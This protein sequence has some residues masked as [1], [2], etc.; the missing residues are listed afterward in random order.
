MIIEPNPFHGEVVLGVIHYFN[1]LGYRI[2]LC[3]RKELMGEKL[4]SDLFFD[5]EIFVFD[6]KNEREIFDCVD[7][8]EYDFAFFTSLEYQNTNRVLVDFISYNKLK[9][10]TKY[11]ILGIYHSNIFLDI[12]GTRKLAEEGRIFCLSEFQRL[13][14]TMNILNP[15][16]FN[17]IGYIPGNGERRNDVGFVK[18]AV[19]GNMFKPEIM[20]KAI[21]KLSAK[22]QKKIII[23][24]T[25][26]KRGK[27]FADF[28][29]RKTKENIY[30]FLAKFNDRWEGKAYESRVIE[31]GRL[32][33]PDLFKFLG[34]ID[35]L[36]MPLDYHT[37][38]GMHYIS[39]STS[40]TKQI[41][42]GMNIPIICNEVIGR[43][44]G[45]SKQNAILYPEN[46]LET[47][48]QEILSIDIEEQ[49]KMRGNLKVTAGQIKEKS[50]ENLKNTI[51]K[52]EKREEYE[53]TT[54]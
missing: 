30:R 43:Q 28:V 48:L 1:L 38:E 34:G 25:G 27:G 41:S 5:G 10:R 51:M 26:G 21:K 36:L 4:I 29:K 3:V 11:G 50:L 20:A 13:M 19:L 52:L 37:Y 12:F 45:F 8:E 40:G 39:V 42:L 24:H 53:D 22:E 23:Y 9:I 7:I 49:A 17:N 2:K 32:N 31:M 35:Y 18:I 15:H 16:C 44:Y 6:K 14:P 33:F 46:R 47:A 54:Y